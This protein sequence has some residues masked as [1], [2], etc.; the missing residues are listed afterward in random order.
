MS[1]ALNEEKISSEQ[2]FGGKL[3]EVYCD[4]VRLPGGGEANREWIDHP[5]AAAVVPLFEDGTTLLVRQ[6]R[7]AAGR[8]FLEVPA[9]KI[10]RDGEDPAEVARRELKEETGCAAERI[11]RVGQAYPCIGYSNEV[12]HFFVARGLTRGEQ[13]LGDTE[14]IEVVPISF[15]EAAEKA[16]RGELLDMKTVAALFYAETYLQR[17]KEE[18]AEE[19]LR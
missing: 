8:T 4:A 5:G 2:V 6:H 17:Q 3:L 16:R 11:E 19:K 10:D 13:D 14:F 12:I 1:D 15:E 18:I 9:G 7:Y